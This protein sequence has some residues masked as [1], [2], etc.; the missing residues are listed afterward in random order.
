[1]IKLILYGLQML[2]KGILYSFLGILAII[3]A[4]AI[5]A[6]ILYIIIIIRK[7]LQK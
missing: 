5:F 3:L 7:M 1:M 4:I 6:L 2:C